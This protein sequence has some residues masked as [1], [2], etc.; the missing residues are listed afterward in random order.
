M[1]GCTGYT[2]NWGALLE[3]QLLTIKQP[4]LQVKIATAQNRRLIAGIASEKDPRLF[5]LGLVAWLMVGFQASLEGE[6]GW[7]PREVYLVAWVVELV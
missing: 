4:R 1:V 3:E 2:Q 7:V 5:G 6:M